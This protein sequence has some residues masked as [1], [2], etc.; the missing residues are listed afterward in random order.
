MVLKISLKILKGKIHFL[1]MTIFLDWILNHLIIRLKVVTKYSNIKK[2][3]K[4][5]EFP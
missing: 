5:N 3:S 2:I 4:D 1:R